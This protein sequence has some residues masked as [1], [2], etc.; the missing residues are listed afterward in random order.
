MIEDILIILKKALKEEFLKHKIVLSPGSFSIKSIF[1]GTNFFNV[2]K[3][4]EQEIR[5][6]IGIGKYFEF[7]PIQGAII[8]EDL[9]HN[10]YL[11]EFKSLNLNGKQKSDIKKLEIH[12][13]SK[14]G[15]IQ[16]VISHHDKLADDGYILNKHSIRFMRAGY[17]FLLSNNIKFFTN[18]NY[19]IFFYPEKTM[20]LDHLHNGHKFPWIVF[21][22]DLINF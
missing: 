3:K 4:I 7:H 11:L 9:P 20:Y 8:W 6:I 15:S 18:K 5:N 16:N 2:D 14:K 10:R 12:L 21:P 19:T 1:S 13:N 17:H 22:N